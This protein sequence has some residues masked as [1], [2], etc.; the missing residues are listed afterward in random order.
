MI[1]QDS[2]RLCSNNWQQPRHLAGLL[3]DIRNGDDWFCGA[4][5]LNDI[6]E[7]DEVE[8]AQIHCFV[9]V[10]AHTGFEIGGIGS[11][12]NPVKGI[13]E[14]RSL[15]RVLVP[16]GHAGGIMKLDAFIQD[17]DGLNDA[18]IE[19]NTVMWSVQVDH[20]ALLFALEELHFIV[21]LGNLSM[22][23]IVPE[24]IDHG[25]SPSVPA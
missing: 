14:A 23:G 8:L 9:K 7:G 13:R 19:G 12:L 15:E 11:V 16:E 3:S 20:Q 10:S 25:I 18:E 2:W 4:D 1:F 24:F 6:V 22:K 5:D 21:L 17:V